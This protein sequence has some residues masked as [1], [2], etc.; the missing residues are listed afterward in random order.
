MLETSTDVARHVAHEEP[1]VPQQQRD[2]VRPILWTLA[3]G[4]PVTCVSCTFLGHLASMLRRQ[5]RPP[6][7]RLPLDKGR[8]RILVATW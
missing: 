7:T 1:I 4:S 6:S 2:D 8:L 5:I 3:H